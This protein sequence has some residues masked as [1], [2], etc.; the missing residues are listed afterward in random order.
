MPV[1]G[2]GITLEAGS[3]AHGVA[4][5][6]L[7]FEVGAATDGVAVAS[8]ALDKVTGVDESCCKS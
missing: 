5:A 8:L 3:T 6:S 1:A 7:A 2:F 4:I